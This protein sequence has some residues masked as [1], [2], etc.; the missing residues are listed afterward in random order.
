MTS[1]VPPARPILSLDQLEGVGPHLAVA[2]RTHFR[3]D[4]HAIEAA[5][6]SNVAALSQ[7]PGISER[8]A[9]DLIRQV[10]G[11]ADTHGFLATPAARKV[12]DE[13]IERIAGYAA[14]THGRNRLR[15]LAPLPTQA[16][17]QA[18]A[19][20]AMRHKH[21]VAA[22]DRDEVRRLLRKVRDPVTPPPRLEATRM[23][24]CETDA[25]QERLLR[26]D[27]QRW[28]AL[29]GQR[30][31]EQAA[32]YDLVLF[33]Y[34]DGMDLNGLDNVV[35]LPGNA[36]PEAIAPEATVAWFAANRDPLQAVAALAA[37]LGRPSRAPE[38]LEVLDAARQAQTTAVQLRKEVEA[39]RVRLD[40]RL[41]ERLASIT[42]TGAD[43]ID[44]I[45]RRMPAPVQ[46]A[47]EETLA[48]A[49]R[50]ITAATGCSFQPFQAAA[51]LALDEEELA[52]VERTLQTRGR[53]DAFNALV[54]AARQLAR[55]RPAVEEEIQAWQAFDVEFALGCFAHHFDLRPARFG[56]A[57]ALSGSIHLDLA[58]QP[59]AQR[60][61]Y[62]IGREETVALLTGANSGGKTTLLEHMAQLAILA[63]LGL[64][65]VGD[66]EVPWIEELHYVTARR[67][68]DAGA[69]ESFLRGFMPLAMPGPRRLVL[70]DE[71]ES[72]TELEAAGRILGFFLDRIATG[73]SLAVVVSHMAP[74]ILA[75]CHA[76]VRIDGIE[77]T[78]LDPDNRL[79][80]DRMPRMGVL[81]R[82]TPEFIVQRLAATTKGAERALYGELLASFKAA[83]PP[84]VSVRARGKG[85]KAG[86]VSPEA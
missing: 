8:K 30:D 71:V 63:R 67:S 74:Q 54:R 39:L 31:L 50:A 40:A 37:T 38:A 45:G 44:S 51:P 33:L 82:S 25:I 3:S 11:L 81:A 32:E 35:E 36:P 83:P 49:R 2:L 26:L 21:I 59:A 6:R 77:A 10:Q 69:F 19:E 52:K 64:P 13:L 16:A 48:E 42:L 28:A 34:E 70:A 58:D 23:V 61:D 62:H 14:T 79:V 9:L 72:V 47:I 80:V 56:P 43:L 66:V 41:R 4:A 20:A 75:H 17:A 12:H 60:I 65:V 53:I 84:A 55:L 78:G 85:T 15:L 76:P 29:G 5:R 57:L 27:L 1:G 22:L 24:L 68:L 7:V 73:D 46:K 86:R 18:S